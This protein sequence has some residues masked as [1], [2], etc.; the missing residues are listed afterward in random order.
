MA[1]SWRRDRP[2][3]PLI[4]PPGVPAGYPQNRFGHTRV[5]GLAKYLR[6]FRNNRSSTDS[7]LIVSITKGW[8]GLGLKHPAIGAG[9]V[10]HLQTVIA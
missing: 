1:A 8:R 10:I 3:R 5:N 9:Y 6:K 7:Q 4:D 2:L